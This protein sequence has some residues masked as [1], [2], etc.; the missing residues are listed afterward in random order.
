[1]RLRV[2][3]ME[4]K[5]NAYERTLYVKLDTSLLCQEDPHIMIV[6]IMRLMIVLV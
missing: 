2:F 4:N 1:M 5:T 6:M 3:K